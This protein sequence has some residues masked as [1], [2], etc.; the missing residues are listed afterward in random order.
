MRLNERKVFFVPM[1][2]TSSCKVKKS[3]I[4]NNRRLGNVWSQ[5]PG[6]IVT[7]KGYNSLPM[8]KLEQSKLLSHGLDKSTVTW[9]LFL[10]GLPLIVSPE[11]WER[12]HLGRMGVK[13]AG[14]GWWNMQR[15]IVA[16]V[17]RRFGGAKAIN[18][19]NS[20]IFQEKKLKQLAWLC[21]TTKKHL[22]TSIS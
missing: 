4:D 6:V 11:P 2:S 19:S 15:C 17:Q 16:Q 5:Q 18:S 7:C 13:K 14:Q 10:K 8:A 21:L 20:S 9:Y 3:V 1:P 12:W 22:P